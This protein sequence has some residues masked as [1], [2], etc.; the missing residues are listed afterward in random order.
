MRMTL[1][2]MSVLVV[3]CTPL[4]TVP[5]PRVIHREAVRMSDLLGIWCIRSSDGTGCRSYREYFSDSTLR[6]CEFDETFG[7]YVFSIA[8][9]KLNGNEICLKVSSSSDI[10]ATPVGHDF[11][12]ELIELH[13]SS[14]K[15]KAIPGGEI[16]TEHRVSTINQKC[17]PLPK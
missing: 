1:L 12:S 17:L 2:L 9:V 5:Q 4:G 14:I 10:G 16:F 8:K 7:R 15:Y 6:S 11:C 3:G 13:G